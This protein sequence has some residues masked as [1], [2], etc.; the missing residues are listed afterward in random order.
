LTLPPVAVIKGGAS[1]ERQ[2]SLRGARRVE[3]ALRKAGYDV[4]HVEIDHS[5]LD[6][7]R[8]IRPRFAFIVAHGRGGEDGALQ[9]LL[10]LLGVPYTGSD[11]L[12]SS[13]CIDKVLTKRLLLRAGLPT[14]A[15]HEFSRQ[16]F[17][18]LGAA[19]ALPELLDDI[20]VPLVVKPVTGGS[21]FGLK[22]VSEPADLRMA[23]L[24]AVAYD[25]RILVER[26]VHGRELAVTVVGPAERPRALPIVEIV[27]ER[28]FYDYE[29]HYDFD[30][31]TLQ[32]PAE[33]DESIRADVEEIATRAYSVLGCR[34]FSR[35][36]LILDADGQAQILELNTIPGLTET[37]PTP[38]AADAAGMSFEQLVEAVSER[39]AREA[40]VGEPRMP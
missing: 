11:S 29:A 21:S 16:A 9:A 39:A 15:F 13:I 37:G 1:F 8:E 12:T 28:R 19:T 14:P 7:I 34:D 10:D 4:V 26:H 40:P 22:L 25:D 31:A 2:V 36:D 38:F 5:L 18:E 20:G 23:L 3:Q 30:V 35:V 24:G 17:E 27:S 6:R 32:A 33:L